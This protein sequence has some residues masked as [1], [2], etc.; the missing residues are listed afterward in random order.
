[1]RKAEIAARLPVRRGFDEN[2][3]A[4]YLSLSPTTFRTLVK[5]GDMPRPRIIGARRIWDIDE[6]DLAFK[7]LPREPSANADGDGVEEW[8]AV[9]S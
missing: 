7:A 4:V 2:E 1:M 6:L 9:L 3:A 5:N 8:D